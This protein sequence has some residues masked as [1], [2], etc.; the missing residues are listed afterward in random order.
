MFNHVQELLQLLAL[1]Q[2][3]VPALV[4]ALVL[5]PVLVL[6]LIPALTIQPQHHALV[7][8]QHVTVN[9]VMLSHGQIK[10]AK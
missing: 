8:Q 3:L 10:A 5:V 7:R 9:V 2:A 1:V 6:A 4:P